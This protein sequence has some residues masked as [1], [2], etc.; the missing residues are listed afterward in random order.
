MVVSGVG[1]DKATTNT[2]VEYTGVGINLKVPQPGAEKLGE[3]ISKILKDPSYTKKAKAL[4]KKFDEY[5]FAKVF[6]GTIQEIVRDWRQ[7]R[8]SH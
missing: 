6:D 4:S 5:D 7:A 3:A 1:Q 8:S 2:I